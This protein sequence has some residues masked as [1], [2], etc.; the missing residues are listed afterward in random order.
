MLLELYLVFL[1]MS[2][3]KLHNQTMAKIELTATGYYRA[4]G[5]TR[6]VLLHVSDKTHE[7]L[8]TLAFKRRESVQK[9]AR[10]LI[11]EGLKKAKL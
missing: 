4:K 2:R 1:L 5:L 8:R 3:G 9:T 11:E 6:S 10:A 7:G